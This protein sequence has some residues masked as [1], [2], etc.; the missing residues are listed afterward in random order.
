MAFRKPPGP[1]AARLL[2]VVGS[3]AYET[4]RIDAPTGCGFCAYA[5][6]LGPGALRLFARGVLGPGDC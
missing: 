4:E 1:Q 5:A 3:A 2:D 6:D